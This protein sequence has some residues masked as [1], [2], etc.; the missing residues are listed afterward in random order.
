MHGA[1]RA[2]SDGVALLDAC[3][4]QTLVTLGKLAALM[5]HLDEHGSDTDA[6]ALAAEVVA[7]FDRT[8]RQHHE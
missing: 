6:K 3:H 2:P 5:S 4:Q 8:G 1:V 7:F